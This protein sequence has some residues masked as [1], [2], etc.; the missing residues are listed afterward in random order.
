MTNLVNLFKA[1]KRVS[2]PLVAIQTPD[3]SATIGLLSGAFNG[4]PPPIFCWDMI[5]GLSPLNEPASAVGAN[6]DVLDPAECLAG[7][8]KSL[9]PKSVVFMLGAHRWIGDA[10]A[11]QAAWNLRDTFKVRA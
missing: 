10:A 1:A 7:P 3:Y 11:A 6:H 8:A 2:T 4:A 9:P 5:R